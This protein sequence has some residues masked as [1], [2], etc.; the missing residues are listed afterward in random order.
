MGVVC[1]FATPLQKGIFVGEVSSFETT[2]AKPDWPIDVTFSEKSG[3]GVAGVC[4][5]MLRDGMGF[6]FSKFQRFE[7]LISCLLINIDPVLPS[8]HVMLSG[9]Y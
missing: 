2:D 4:V 3:G 1:N 9:R 5:G 7:N 8:F 6:N